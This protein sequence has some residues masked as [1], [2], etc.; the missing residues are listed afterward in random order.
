[1]TPSNDRLGLLA[2]RTYGM[3]TEYS[4]VS[5]KDHVD[6]A[7]K[8]LSLKTK[9][10]HNQFISN[11][12]RLY[13]DL[14]HPEYAT[15][16]C[17]DPW[18]LA[19]YHHAGDVI[20]HDLQVEARNQG[21]P[22]QLRRDNI[23]WP[24]DDRAANS[25]G[26]HEN[27]L[28]LARVAKT[29]L[30]RQLIP[31]LVSAPLLFGSGYSDPKGKYHFS[32]RAT[33]L[34]LLESSN[35]TLH[36]RALINTRDE[37]HL[38][39]NYSKDYARLHVTC[40]DANVS[41]QATFLKTASLS[42]ILAMIETGW[43]FDDLMPVQPVQA[44]NCLNGDISGN[45]K[46]ITNSGPKSALEIQLLILSR[47]GIYLEWVSECDRLP[48]WVLEAYR[49]WSQALGDIS[50]FS[51]NERPPSSYWIDWWLKWHLL[52]K[53][54]Q[55]FPDP[56]PAALFAVSMDYHN[57][58]PDESFAHQLI[59]DKLLIRRFS[60]DHLRSAADTPSTHPR[61]IHRAKWIEKAVEDLT[62]SAINWSKCTV[63][64]SI[65]VF[66]FAV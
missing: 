17:L 4:I 20:M 38:P 21:M 23:D 7:D 66:D 59:K 34:D 8:L 61:A 45:V 16:E 56:S 5:E 52:Q 25:Y 55:C 62:I 9:S 31:Y 63:D 14:L 26:C 48:D 44:A 24:Q 27:Y 30:R 3:E 10:L 22:V 29:V 11:S 12:G 49:L 51:L 65:V 50:S 39:I 13:L 47:V 54:R 53:Y 2:R 41:Q 32:V 58:D 6:V 1:M 40:R 60:D 57:L 37:S 43:L 42:I 46:V 15:P 33:V 19:C 28:T 64:N 36:N 18:E 35:A